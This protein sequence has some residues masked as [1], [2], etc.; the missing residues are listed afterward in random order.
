MSGFHQL[1]SNVIV[2]VTYREATSYN[3]DV[4]FKGFEANQEKR[5]N[6][7]AGESESPKGVDWIDKEDDI[8]FTNGRKKMKSNLDPSLTLLRDSGRRVRCADT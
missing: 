5:A 2:L 6:V 1:A 4:D 3:G 7:T 8:S